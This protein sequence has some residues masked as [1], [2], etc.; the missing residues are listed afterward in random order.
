MKKTI[1]TIALMAVLGLVAVG[2]QKESSLSPQSTAT[3]EEATIHSVNYTID[4]VSRNAS[5]VSEE[6]WE[7]FLYRLIAKAEEGYSVSFRN[8]NT[9]PNMK[10][11]REIVTH[12]TRSRKDAYEW[13]DAMEAK[14]YTVHI[15]YDKTTGVY[16]CTAIK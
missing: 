6:E 11:S 10:Q 2:C 14:G 4:G 3:Y 16:T 8:A 12:T 5:F 15:D 7:V 9:G 1:R 13:S